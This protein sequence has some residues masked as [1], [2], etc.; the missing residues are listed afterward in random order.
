MYFRYSIIFEN[1]PMEN[2][3][4]LQKPRPFTDTFFNKKELFT[5]IIQGL[6]ITSGT[7]FAYQYSIRQGYGEALTR[8][9][10]FVTLIVAN[11]FLTLTNRSIYYS[12][13]TT[14]KYKNNMVSIIIL[15]TIFL[16]ALLL[17]I[18]PLTLFFGLEQLSITQIV[19]CT[20]IGFISVIWFEIV[21]LFNRGKNVLNT[22]GKL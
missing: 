18:P 19:I 10:T 11:I 1:E 4:M 15:L 5:S 20:A 2:N 9:I 3:T 17:L 21:K 6:F 12:I 13:I 7:L 8:T 16:N 22:L 14:L